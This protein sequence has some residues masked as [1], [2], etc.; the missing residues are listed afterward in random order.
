M[1]TSD[2]HH[3]P[4]K[5]G[6]TTMFVKNNSSALLQSLSEDELIAI[7]YALNERSERV[8]ADYSIFLGLVADKLASLTDHDFTE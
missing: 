7:V 3:I 6:F 5:V 4:V 2:T 1:S 8:S